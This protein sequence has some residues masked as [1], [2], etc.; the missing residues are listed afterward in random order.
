MITLGPTNNEFKDA[1]ET[2][3]YKWVLAVSKLFYIMLMQRNLFV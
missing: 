2:A 1:T 3:R